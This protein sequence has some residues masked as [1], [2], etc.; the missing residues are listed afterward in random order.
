MISICKV[1]YKCVSELRPNNIRYL[2]SE[3]SISASTLSAC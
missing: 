3:A 2:C 1:L